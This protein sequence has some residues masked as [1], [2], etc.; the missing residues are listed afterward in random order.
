MNYEDNMIY[1]DGPQIVKELSL[2]MRNTM[3][4]AEG[5]L[6]FETYDM[7]Q[8]GYPLADHGEMILRFDSGTNENNELL[9]P[10]GMWVKTEDVKL[11]IMKNI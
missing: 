7:V 5:W 11:W 10:T 4:K 8:C 6:P 1:E 2:E 9:P 3:K